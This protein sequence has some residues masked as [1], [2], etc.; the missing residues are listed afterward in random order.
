M[1]G[2][3]WFRVVTV[4]LTRARAESLCELAAQTVP[5]K[6]KKFFLFT[7][8]ENFSFAEPDAIY[9]QIFVT[10]KNDKKIALMQ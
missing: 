3:D 2:V 8:K 6:M 10:P 7:S 5:E 1:F 9:E 4:T